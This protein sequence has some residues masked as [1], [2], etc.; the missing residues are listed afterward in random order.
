MNICQVSLA[1]NIEIIKE[2][3]KKFELYYNDIYIYIV[4]PEKDFYEFKKQ[5]NK[6]NIKIISEDKIIKFETF[7]KIANTFLQQKKYYNEIQ[8]R[9]GWYYQQVLKISFALNFIFEKNEK[10]IIWDADTILIKKINFFYENNSIIYGTTSE[11]FNAYFK[12][13]KC[14]FNEL[15]NYF[16]SSLCQFSA[17]TQMDAK[18][19]INQLE[20]FETKKTAYSEWI[21]KVI[22]KAICLA[23]E[24]YLGSLFSEYE[25]IGQSKLLSNR[26]EQKLISGM[27]EGLDGKITKIQEII[28]K[29]F[30]YSYIAYEHTHQNKLSKGMLNRNQSWLNFLSL[31]INKSTNKIFRGLKHFIKLKL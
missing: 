28:L 17:L 23:H 26:K 10:I 16:I 29:F 12:T 25:L 6:K 9:L 7:K 20:K 13:N 22:F 27:R 3:L 30:N 5:F 18:N 24:N 4:C 2:N 1:G 8:N 19:L 11:Y 31:L 15:P 21:V 14:I